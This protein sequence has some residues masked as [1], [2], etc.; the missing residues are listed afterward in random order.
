MEVES[1]ENKVMELL[2]EV[3]YLD[4][5]KVDRNAEFEALGLDS[6]LAVEFVAQVKAQLGVAETIESLYEWK[7]PKAFIEHVRGQVVAGQAAP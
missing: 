6:V 2:A 4:V 5:S 1:I 7:T 3:L